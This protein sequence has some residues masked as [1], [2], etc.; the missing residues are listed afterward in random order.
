MERARED[1]QKMKLPA[2]KHTTK[3]QQAAEQ[4]ANTFHSPDFQKKVECEQQRLEQEVFKVYT[5][6]WVKTKTKPGARAIRHPCEH[7]RNLSLFLK[8]GTG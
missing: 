5:Q 1:A 4:T 6:P 7:R 3:G 2:N 8:L